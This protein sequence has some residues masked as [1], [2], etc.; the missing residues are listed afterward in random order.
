MPLYTF[1]NL[2]TDEVY[3]KILTYDEYKSMLNKRISNKYL[4]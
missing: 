3:D 2:E 1:K 4:N